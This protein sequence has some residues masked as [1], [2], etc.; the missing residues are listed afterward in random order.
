MPNMRWHRLREAY[1]D[2]GSEYPG[3]Y[4]HR[5]ASAHG[6]SGWTWSQWWTG[7][8]RQLDHHRETGSAL[9]TRRGQP[10]DRGGGPGDDRGAR[11]RGRGA[12]ANREGGTY[13]PGGG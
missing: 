7:G 1:Q 13:G 4:R 10:Q 6:R 9:R 12:E 8:R 11:R 5:Q 3:W 2:A